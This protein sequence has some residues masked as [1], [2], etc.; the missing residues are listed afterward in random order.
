MK[1]VNQSFTTKIMKIAGKFQNNLVV[2]SITQGMMSTMPILMGSAIINILINLPI[3]PWINFLKDTGLMVPLSEI[4]QI[5]TCTGLFI[6]FGI[7]R[8]ISEKMGAKNPVE[9]GIIALFSFLI[10][11]PLTTVVGDYGNAYSVGLENLGAQGIITSMIVSVCA[12]VLFMKLSKTPLRIKMPASVPPFVSQSFENIPGFVITLVPFIALRV[13]FGLTP[14]GGFTPFINT[15]IQAPLTGIGN[16]LTGHLVLLI[17]CSLLWWLGLHG[18]M[19]IMPVIMVLGTAPLQ[20][21]IAAVASGMAAPNLLT[22]MSIMAIIQMVGGPGCLFGLFIDMA[23]FTKSERYKTQGK[24]QL[25][26]GLFN[27][28][29]PVVYGLPIVLN[30]TLL[31]PFV[32]LPVISYILMYFGMKLQLFTTPLTMATSFIPG[33]ILGFLASGGIGFGIFIVLMCVLSCIVYY[34]FVKIMDTQ[35]LKLESEEKN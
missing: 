1:A 33:P 8:V 4:V 13:L 28:I 12:G 25:V 7:G 34:P 21:N 29:E 15:V 32:L 18:S 5:A 31:L 6:S 24:L 2:S 19:I 30:F 14:Y 20:E 35:Q 3:T 17:L 11:T 23:F 16:S 26:P 9:G 22:M 10:V 27:V